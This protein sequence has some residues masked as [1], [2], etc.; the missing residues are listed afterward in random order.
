[1]IECLHDVPMT[2]PCDKCCGTQGRLEKLTCHK[3]EV[4][5]EKVEKLKGDIRC[6]VEKAADQHLEGYREQ[7]REIVKQVE[8]AEKAE[9]ELSDYKGM[10]ADTEG[11][12]ADLMV[13]N[14]KAE[15][16]A[17]RYRE[18]LEFLETVATGENQVDVFDDTEALHWIATYIREQALTEPTKPGEQDDD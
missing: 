18:A 17:Q 12:V 13:V 5:N 14:D 9:A 8:R 3:C 10:L 7:G 1:M 11:A 2:E 15:A 6:M 16:T 4:L